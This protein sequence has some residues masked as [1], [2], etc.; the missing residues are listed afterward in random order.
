MSDA[1]GRAA[2]SPRD[3]F[4]AQL[5]GFGPVGIVALVAILVSGTLTVGRV[6]VPLGALLVLAWVRWSGTPW[7]EIG[8]ARPTNWITTLALGLAIGVPFKFLMKAVVMPL[9]GADPINR[10]YHYLAGN[11]AILPA[12]LWAMLVAGFG[13]ETVFR[14][15]LFERLGKLIGARPGAKAAI[16][17][18]TSGLFALA[19]YPDQGLAGAE[20]AM[21][22]GLVFGTIFIVT[23][24]I[25]IP[26]IAHAAY[27][28][29]AL[30]MI[31]GNVE[32][33]VA[34]WI[35]K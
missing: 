13:E 6:A 22:T 14:G 7:N 2:A 4:A 3:G 23:G 21:C 24:Q 5:R 25:W 10:T 12:A 27:D 32:S 1:E 35:F 31:Y 26:M 19:H 17:L 9:F 16:L 8:Y 29:T 11:R 20:Q 18:F 28:L 15:Y 33:A 34:H 30:A